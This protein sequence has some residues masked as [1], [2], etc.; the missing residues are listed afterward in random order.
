MV[1][2]AELYGRLRQAENLAIICH[3]IA[4]WK[5]GQTAKYAVPRDF[6]VAGKI[7][8]IYRIEYIISC[9]TKFLFVIMTV[10]F[11]CT[12]P[13]VVNDSTLSYCGLGIWF[14]C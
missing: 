4:Y 10:V 5:L 12:L 2:S 1:L 14:S 13:C 7:M 8:Y 11:I 3:E 9:I 6:H